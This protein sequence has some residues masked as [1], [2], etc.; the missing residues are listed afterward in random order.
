MSRVYNLGDNLRRVEPWNQGVF[1]HTDR[2]SRRDCSRSQDLSLH[3]Q[4]PDLKLKVIHHYRFI[5]G[6]I[7]SANAPHV[8]LQCVLAECSLWTKR[9]E[10]G[11]P[12]E[13]VD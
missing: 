2:V 9:F 8:I 3:E 12:R 5:R 7:M 10:R 6:W 1:M 13:G 4:R 11:L